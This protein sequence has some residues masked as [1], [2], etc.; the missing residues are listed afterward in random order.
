MLRLLRRAKREALGAIDGFVLRR[1]LAGAGTGPVGGAPLVAGF[2]SAPIGLG[3]GARLVYG[4]L[5]RGGLDPR[6]FDV[7]PALQP[8]RAS[9]DYGGDR[10]SGETGPVILHVNGPEILRAMRLLGPDRLRHRKLIGFWNWE[11][12]TPPADWRRAGAMLDE[13]WVPSRFTERS[14]STLFPGKVRYTGYP[15]D[16]RDLPAR[17]DEWLEQR[18]GLRSGSFLVYSAF[19]PRSSLDRKNPLGAVRAFRRAFP[20][21]GADSSPVQ[22]LVKVTG[23]E[24]LRA[25][26]VEAIGGDPRIVLFSD[27][28]SEA[29]TAGLYASVDC[30]L[31]LHRAEGYGLSPAKALSCGTPT[32]MTG[33][34]SVTD[35]LG[36][37]AA[38]PVSY[39]LVPVTDG[40]GIYSAYGGK[41]AEPDIDHAAQFL[42]DIHDM[43]PGARA[44]Q[45]SA[46]RA[47]WKTNHGSQHFLDRTTDLLAARGR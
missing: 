15:I 42:R 12:E 27:L 37:P 4:A 14:L 26:L 7:T 44:S 19:D 30:V 31:S 32:V 18:F 28:L 17:D 1:Q 41:W 46:A 6:R 24:G 34:S 8:D 38:F 47:W 10:L 45:A 35:F 33:W 39:D 21:R 11:L 3:E 20:D 23:P 9:L 16:G 13:I 5:H 36:S 25:P 43:D 2:F 22:M 29:E 40:L